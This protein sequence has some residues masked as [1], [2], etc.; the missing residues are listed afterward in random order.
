MAVQYAL[1]WDSP[2]NATL[3]FSRLAITWAGIA[4][5]GAVFFVVN[6]GG[7]KKK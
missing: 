1:I 2:S 5:A 4:I 7:E 6:I 3:D